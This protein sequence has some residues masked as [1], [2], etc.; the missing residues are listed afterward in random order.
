MPQ[1]PTSVL[2]RNPLPLPASPASRP[3]PQPPPATSTATPP[4]RSTPRSQEAKG[5]RTE[6]SRLAKSRCRRSGESQCSA[7]S[8][9]PTSSSTWMSSCS[10]RWASQGPGPPQKAVS[11][12]QFCKPSHQSL[13]QAGL[14]SPGP[15][16]QHTE[17]SGN[18]TL[19]PK[20]GISCFSV[21]PGRGSREIAYSLHSSC[22]VGMLTFCYKM[23]VLLWGAAQNVWKRVT[24]ESSD[25]GTPATA[26]II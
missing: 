24:P 13:Y 12:W 8:P 6:T 15:R 4:A 1:R 16:F 2:P 25:S 7:R 19:V 11:T 3:P 9:T 21:K 18:H 23:C 5:R 14:E 20:F 22:L 26:G 10:T 17:S